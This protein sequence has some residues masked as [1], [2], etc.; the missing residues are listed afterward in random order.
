MTKIALRAGAGSF[1]VAPHDDALHPMRVF[2][3]CPNSDVRD[4]SIMIAMHG[5]DRAAEGFR[6]DMSLQAFRNGQ[7]VLVPE[8]DKKHFPD[9]FSYNFGGVRLPPPSATVLA[10]DR[11]NF[12]F[13]DRLFHLVRQSIGSSRTTFGMYGNSAGAQY[14]LR[15]L[16]LMDAPA[17]HAAVASNSGAYMVP[18]LMRDYPIGMGGLDLNEGNLRRYLGRRL[19][20]LIGSLDTDANAHDLPRWDDAAAQG[21]H[22]LAR[23]QWYFEH[24]SNLAHRLDSP[25]NWDME[26]VEGAAHISPLIY[27]RASDLLQGR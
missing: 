27:A 20:L 22:R 9:H 6:D 26:V 7:I 17:V 12:A 5:M 24:C 13:I 16:A 19:T 8:F 2:Y 11:W 21:P 23:G 25:L 4:A 10:R 1:Q 18:D 3:A 15:Y 14:V